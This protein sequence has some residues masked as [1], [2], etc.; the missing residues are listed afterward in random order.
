MASPATSVASAN[1]SQP[2][3]AGQPLWQRVVKLT[4]APP[5]VGKPGKVKTQAA[6]VISDL[7]VKFK[8]VKTLRKEPNTSTVEVYN[9]TEAHRKQMQDDGT[10]IWLEAGYQGATGQL[11]VGDARY[12]VHSREKCDWQTKI[13]LGDGER[14]YRFG[15]VQSSFKAGTTA[16]DIL[17]AIVAQAG[18][19]PGNVN[20]QTFKADLTAQ[21]VSGWAFY[22]P[23]HKALDQVLG[24]IG[25]T[26][27]VQGN[28]LQILP[29]KGYT[30]QAVIL[31]DADHGLI[32]SPEMG[33]AK[34][35]KGPRTLKVKCLLQP[36][37]NPGGRINLQSVSFHGVFVI[38]K[39]EHVG[40]TF[41][42]EWFSEL[43]VQAV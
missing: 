20:D 9:L 4:I 10:R 6:F 19:D 1:A 35:A 18:F 14:A 16:G 12:I 30:P 7:R 13:E 25:Y 43:E 41:A 37:L 5:L 22:G 33:S 27:S 34:K 38:Q 11:F 3:Q 32:G 40:D 8:I 36:S 17:K 21:Q 29:K 2:S 31:L 23:G 15:R 42:G 26:W 24:P 28:A 39:V